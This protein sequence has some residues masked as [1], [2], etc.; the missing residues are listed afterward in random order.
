MAE[1]DDFEHSAATFFRDAIEAGES[2]ERFGDDALR[3]LVASLTATGEEIQA[4]ADEPDKLDPAAHLILYAAAAI[5][6]LAGQC[7]Q[8]NEVIEGLA[9]DL[10]MA[11]A[12]AKE[13]D[14]GD[15]KG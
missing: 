9:V 3:E 15:G 14:R 10:D 8:D 1:Q 5:T 12:A 13:G 6:F 11:R 7:K 4:S 2:D